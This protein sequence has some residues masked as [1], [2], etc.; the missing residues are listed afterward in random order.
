MSRVA[1]AA[2]SLI[3]P[4][5]NGL[6]YAYFEGSWFRLPDLAALTPVKTG[7]VFDTTLEPAGSRENDFALLFK[8]YVQI[9]KP[10]EYTFT[11]ISDD[12]ALIVIGDTEV[13]HNDGVFG[14]KEVSGKITLE[15]GKHPLEISYFQ[16]SGGRTLEILCEGPGVE[17]Q[18][19]PPHWL[20]IK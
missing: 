11:T 6:E 9:D 2:F 4:E 15:A 1:K 20:F 19:L 10:G 16:K 18:N 13:V 7:R 8:G 5:Q 3:D 12:G 17:K 14:I